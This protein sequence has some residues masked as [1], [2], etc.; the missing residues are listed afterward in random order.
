LAVIPTTYG[1][2]VTLA[3]VTHDG[4]LA[5][6]R[7]FD[8]LGRGA[9]LKLSGFG[10]ARAYYLDHQGQL[11]DS[12]AIVGYAHGVSTLSVRLS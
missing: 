1:P 9:F 7:K 12:K 8:D 3:D 11:Y 2:H 10:P 4:V 6:V 5:A